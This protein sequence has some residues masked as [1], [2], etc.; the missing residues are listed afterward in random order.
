MK[1]KY[2]KKDMTFNIFLSSLFAPPLSMDA[3]SLAA[4][5]NIPESVLS[6]LRHGRQKRL[7]V[8]FQ[9]EL[10]ASRFAFDLLER[11]P[12][13]SATVK[14]FLAY[15]QTISEKYILSESLGRYL[16]LFEEEAA[17]VDEK[18]IEKFCSGM[19]PVLMSYCYEEA[20]WNTQ[21]LWSDETGSEIREREQPETG[22]AYQERTRLF[23]DLIYAEGMMRDRPQDFIDAAY[24]EKI[25]NI[26]LSQIQAPFYRRIARRERISLSAKRTFLA[27]KIT[28]EE[29]LVSPKA[30]PVEFMLKQTVYHEGCLTEEQVAGRAFANFTCQVDGIFLNDYLDRKEHRNGAPGAPA[31]KIARAEHGDGLVCSEVKLTFRLYPEEP[32]R[33]IRVLYAYEAKSRYMDRIPTV[34]SYS[35]RYPCESFSHDFELSPQVRA[36][37]GLQIR[38]VIPEESITAPEKI[39]FGSDHLHRKLYRIAF[40]KWAI[41]GS[42]YLVSMYRLGVGAVFMESGAV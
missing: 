22:S 27:S 9:P 41:P 34:F 35:L 32:S 19:L 16:S 13:S 14:R 23:L 28:G 42:G 1:T 8:S 29:E 20:Y 2:A 31:M 21:N 24:L 10:M 3:A 26:L 25:G 15:T 7:P 36:E 12:C 38:T 5:F 17:L 33:P 39:P 4:I 18:Q 30:E 6:G 11:F 40:R 37:W